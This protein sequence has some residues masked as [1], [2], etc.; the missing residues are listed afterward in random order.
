MSTPEL[1]QTESLS[2]T[3]NLKRTVEEVEAG[4][5]K[6][7]RNEERFDIRLVN[8]Y[9][10]HSVIGLNWRYALRRTSL[11]FTSCWD[12]KRASWRVLV[13]LFLEKIGVIGRY[14]CFWLKFNVRNT[15]CTMNHI[16]GSE[17]DHLKECRLWRPSLGVSGNGEDCFLPSPGQ[18]VNLLAKTL[19]VKWIEIAKWH[20]NR[21]VTHRHSTSIVHRKSVGVQSRQFSSIFHVITM[22]NVPKV[23]LKL[24]QI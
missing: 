20:R 24:H 13:I 14:T 9:F 4:L 17:L 3:R 12:F 10:Y 22:Q 2:W 19:I 5:N 16:R 11:D 1:N 6:E 15:A 21:E 8:L 7:T 18:W 23:S